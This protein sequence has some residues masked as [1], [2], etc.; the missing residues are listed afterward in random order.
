M[1]RI[2]LS[3]AQAQR[4]EQAFRSAT[5]VKLRDRLN[6]V[7]LA[8][9]GVPRQDIADQLAVQ[10]KTIKN[11]LTAIYTK[12]RVRNRNEALLYYWGIG[13]R[14]DKKHP[15]AVKRLP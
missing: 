6:A 3:E 2:Q 1:I 12:L 11:A 8:H 9:R 14:D 4:L 5:D 10:C 13:V 15:A 7:R